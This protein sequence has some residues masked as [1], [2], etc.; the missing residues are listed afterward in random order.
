MVAVDLEIGQLAQQRLEHLVGGMHVFKAGA[1]DRILHSGV[2]GV[3]GDDVVDAHRGQF[4]KRHGAV[5]RLA[6]GA[7]VLTA[8]IEVRHD[9][10]D[11][12]GLLALGGDDALEVLEVV[13]RRHGHV[14]AV[15]AVG[16]GIVGHVAENV[17]V[18]A[19]YALTDDG[20]AFAGRE[21]GA[22]GVQ[23]EVAAQI[24]GI[25]QQNLIG[26]FGFF[27]PLNQIGVDLFAQA[28]A[29]V[30]GN[31]SKRSDRLRVVTETRRD[32]R[33]EC[34]LPT[35]CK[36][37]I[38]RLDKKFCKNPSSTEYFTIPLSIKYDA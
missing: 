21:A 16:V 36:H 34:Y 23:Q 19:A 35:Y 24:A 9:D 12:L 5:Q 27:F 11:A 13:V 17:E 18:I 3:E 10:R 7:A 6:G 2:V 8:F 38:A 32:V 31:N 29:A 33:H 30:H 14:H 4:L 22:V 20:L 15:H 1:R 37:S 28:L 26:V 25:G